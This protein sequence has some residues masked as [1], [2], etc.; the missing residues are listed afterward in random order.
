MAAPPRLAITPVRAPHQGPSTI[1]AT[2]VP[3][4]S[5][6]VGRPSSPLIQ[7]PTMS[8]AA[9]AGTSVTTRVVGIAGVLARTAGAFI[10]LD[11]RCSRHDAWRCATR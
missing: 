2:Q 5:M 10:A 9:A 11:P 6:N 3:I 8:R 4:M 1:A 7:P